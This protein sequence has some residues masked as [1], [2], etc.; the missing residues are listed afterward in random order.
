MLKKIS[1]RHFRKLHNIIY[2]EICLIKN[3]RILEFGV[4][5][6]AMSTN[7]FLDFCKS[8]NGMLYSVDINNYSNKFISSHWKFIKSR[9]DDFFF[10]EKNS[11]HFL[12]HKLIKSFDLLSSKIK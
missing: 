6:K 5:E 12:L 4:S 1:D 7:F 3:P 9:D 10:I 11:L 8:N 2:K